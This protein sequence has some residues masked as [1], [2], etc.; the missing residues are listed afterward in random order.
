MKLKIIYTGGL[1]PELDKAL[2]DTL[3]RSGLIWRAS[4]YNMST[5]ERDLAF[6]SKKPA[7][8]PAGCCGNVDILAILSDPKAP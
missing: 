4:G 7:G 8:V 6:E 3:K 2:K 1:N 5:E